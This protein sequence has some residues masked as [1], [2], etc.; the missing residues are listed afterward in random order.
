M[1]KLLPSSLREAII[2]DTRIGEK[3]RWMYDRHNL[4]LLMN[5][6]GFRDTVFRTAKESGI[7]GFTQDCLDVESDGTVYK[8]FSLYCEARKQ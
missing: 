4:G 2:D 8:P 7:Q 3:H 1:K 6:C 5:R